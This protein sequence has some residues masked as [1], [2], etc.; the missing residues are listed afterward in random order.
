MR[1]TFNDKNLQEKFEHDGFVVIPLLNE[2]EVSALKECYHQ[3]DASLQEE[4]YLSIWSSDEN[5]KGETQKKIIEIIQEKAKAVLNKYRHIVSNFA[6]KFPGQ[7]SD[8][9]LHQGINFIDES[10]GDVSITMWIPLQDV[11]LQNGNMQVVRGSHKFF[12]QD[13]RSQHYQTPYEDIKTYIKEN[14]LENLPMKAGEAW[15]FNHRL[16]HCSPI[17]ST[18]KVRIATLNIM[19]PEESQVLLYYKNGENYASKDVDILH[20]TEDNYHLQDVYNKPNLTGINNVGHATELHY[21]V[22]KQEFDRL[23]KNFIEPSDS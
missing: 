1:P 3:L 21:K 13:V 5:Y 22:D 19:V 14:Y 6:V 17:N 4:F 15:V 9:D 12:D 18:D 16:L 2:E 8:F 23:Y 11:N 20:F 7:K 10:K